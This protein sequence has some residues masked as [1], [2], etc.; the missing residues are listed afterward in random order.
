MKPLS[1]TYMAHL[2]GGFLLH[3]GPPCL[4]D[5]IAVD[6]RT[7]K[8][9]ALFFALAGEHANGHDFVKDAFAKGAVAAVVS[10]K[11]L[12]R[13]SFPTQKPLIVVDDPL[14]ALQRAATNH[15][16]RFSQLKKIGISGSMGKTTTK[17]MLSSIL[18]QMGTVTKTPGNYNSTIGLPI[19]LLHIDETTEFG[20]FEMGIDRPNEME[21]LLSRWQP[22]VGIITRIGAAHLKTLGSEKH[23]AQEK[24][25]LF[26]PSIKTALLSNTD[27]W[28]AYIERKQGIEALRFG[29]GATKGI[30][31][32]HHL[33]LDGWLIGYKGEHIHLKA[34]GEHNLH[35]ACAAITAAQQLGASVSA[36]CEGL[37]QFRAVQGRSNVVQG[38]ITLIEDWYNASYDSTLSII[39]YVGAL[40]WKGRKVA[41]LGSMKELGSHSEQA[42]RLVARRLSSYRLDALYLYGQEMAS[43]KEELMRLGLD[44]TC[45]YTTDSE[46]LS[47]M[48]STQ[49]RK[50]DL[51]LIKGSRA[52]QM[53]QLVPLVS[54]L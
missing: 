4:I 28:S 41:V 44:R 34:I 5:S 51:V 27:R 29:L 30:D 39:D 11:E 8:P 49:S 50:G 33:G 31:S 2:C 52:M 10:K 12:Q 54:T 16:Q 9:G 21:S 22:Q 26:H 24:G 7:I 32:Y 40:P 25:K 1:T 47:H 42:H 13:G 17:E 35:N 19:S 15:V 43:A 36:I 53:E 3:K 46:Q 37:E 6:S 14:A 20:L 18:E 48:V 45:F 38:D 23:I